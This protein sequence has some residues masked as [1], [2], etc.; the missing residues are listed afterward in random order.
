MN[1]KFPVV[2]GEEPVRLVTSV[3]FGAETPVNVWENGLVFE[4]YCA[5][6]TAAYD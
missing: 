5:K 6:D 2:E 3:V 4:A 1:V